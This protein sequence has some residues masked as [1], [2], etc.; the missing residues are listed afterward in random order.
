MFIKEKLFAGYQTL[1]NFIIYK[2]KIEDKTKSST[3]RNNFLVKVAQQP[4]NR[5]IFGLKK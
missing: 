3:S 4:E 2:Y 5:R 1:N